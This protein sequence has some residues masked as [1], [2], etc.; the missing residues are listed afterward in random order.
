MTGGIDRLLVI[1]ISFGFSEA[2]FWTSTPRQVDRVFRACDRRLDRDHA[3][4]AWLAWH[5]AALTR[6]KRMPQLDKMLR[7]AAA[8]PRR[9]QTWQEQMAIMGMWAATMKRANG[10][11][12]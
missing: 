11:A 7:K 10:R 5:I 1:W 8:T 3:T 4:R 2:E 6:A 9:R 12:G